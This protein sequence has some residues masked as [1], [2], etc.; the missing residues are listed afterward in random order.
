MSD[1]LMSNREM[2][3]VA[4]Y[5][6]NSPSFSPRRL[7]RPRYSQA[8]DSPTNRCAQRV[9]LTDCVPLDVLTDA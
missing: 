1:V 7:L 3:T 5:I 2:G 9:N 8:N 6:L 4:I